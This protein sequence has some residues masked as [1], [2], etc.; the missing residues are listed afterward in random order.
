NEE[1]KDFSNYINEKY[2]AL[3]LM[4]EIDNWDF[5]IVEASYYSNS[6][7]TIIKYA[8]IIGA[9]LALTS[10]IVIINSF[11]SNIK[12]RKQQIGMLRAVG[13]TK[14]QIMK[15]LGREA[16][17]IS[18]VSIPVSLVISYL[19]VLALSTLLDESFVLTIDVLSVVICGVA[20]LITVMLAALIPIVFAT[21]ITPMQ[22]IR[23]ID[24]S[25]K[26]KTKKIKTQKSF[27]VPKLLAERTMAFHKG[28][29]IAVSILLVSTIFLSC[30][31]LSYVSYEENHP[32]IA[33]YDY[34]VFCGYNYD[35]EVFT[36]PLDKNGA[37]SDADK[38]TIS[39]APYISKAFGVK[40]CNINVLI[41][42]YTD[43]FKIL[44][45][46]SVYG[47]Y[48]LDGYNGSN[49]S[50][51][52]YSNFGKYYSNVKSQAGYSKDFLPSTL[53][54]VDDW[55]LQELKD[56]L[57]SGEINLDKLALGEEIIL[58][59]PQKAAACVLDDN[60][61]ITVLD[62]GLDD[63]FDYDVYGECEYRAGDMIDLSVLM[64][65]SDFD[66]IDKKVKIGAVISPAYLQNDASNRYIIEYGRGNKFGVLTSIAGMN[67]F[68]KNEKYQNIYMF[69]DGEIKEE[70]DD[71][72]N[73][74]VNPILYKYKGGVLS[75]YKSN[76]RIEVENNSMLVAMISLIIIGFAI[77][78]SLTN[79]TYTA[80]IRERKREL[81]T[82]RA[83]G[84]SRKEFV[85]SYV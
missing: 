61:A 72:V 64:G 82:L 58:I 3:N 31:G 47:D 54:A 17:M 21:R 9:V 67:R 49:Y 34:S 65:D 28:N 19:F 10:C 48:R 6:L 40:N 85:E 52:V 63:R 78:A 76:K 33:G 56:S 77:C 16:L 42:E 14:R 27:S 75:N 73:S 35:S 39:A 83:V 50:E 59:A 13:T 25:R 32:Y 7:E 2:E 55:K 30:V 26:M 80:S 46:R 66:R 53:Y 44:G 5:K 20:G 74:Y 8:G 11:N 37:I 45:G 23:N 62:D 1:S 41:D 57:V 4:D 70:I 22:A 43:Y 29:Q 38:Q 84:I 18:L 79:N 68:S 81:G 12:E 36:N 15:V 60:Y 51:L 69:V 71:T 24:A